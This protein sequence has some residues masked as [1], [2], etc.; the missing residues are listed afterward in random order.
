MIMF[1]VLLFCFLLKLYSLHVVSVIIYNIIKKDFKNIVI[2]LYPFRYGLFTALDH[3]TNMFL[4][5]Y[6]SLYSSWV[7]Y[8]LSFRNQLLVIDV[9]D[10]KNKLW[11]CILQA[12]THL[13]RLLFS[14]VWTIILRFDAPKETEENNYET[15]LNYLKFYLNLNELWIT[16]RQ[17][18][19]NVIIYPILH[20]NI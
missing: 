7:S 16:M 3:P 10:Y 8:G 6:I 1:L 14:Y 4:F 12:S 9:V 5:F 11:Y 13:S 2:N 20:I 19:L 15:L 18:L 17:Y